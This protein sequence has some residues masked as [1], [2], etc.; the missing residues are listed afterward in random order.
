MLQL[1]QS[2]APYD[3][4][5]CSSPY[6]VMLHMIQSYAEMNPPLIP[7]EEREGDFSIGLQA[8]SVRER[9]LSVFFHSFNIL[10]LVDN[11]LI[12]TLGL[13]VHGEADDCTNSTTDDGAN[14]H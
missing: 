4:E 2:Y 9:L 10:Y 5:L 8:R 12:L 3:T 14:N 6:R 11:L 13:E 7:H 1:L